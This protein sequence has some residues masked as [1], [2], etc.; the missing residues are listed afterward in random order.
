MTTPFRDIPADATRIRIRRP[1]PWGDL[2]FL[3]AEDLAAY[4]PEVDPAHEQAIECASGP[5]L[6]HTGSRMAV[7]EQDV[8]VWSDGLLVG[9]S[10]HAPHSLRMNRDWELS[11]QRPQR[12]AVV[13]PLLARILRAENLADLDPN[14]WWMTWLD[15][16][17]WTKQPGMQVERVD[18]ALAADVCA[19]RTLSIVQH[20]I[21]RADGTTAELFEAHS[22]T[23]YRDADPFRADMR[24]GQ[25][26]PL[27]T[28]SSLHSTEALA[29][30]VLE[31]WRAEQAGHPP[32]VTRG[33]AAALCDTTPQAFAQALSRAAR[34][35]RPGT[36]PHPKP[37]ATC[38]GVHWLDPRRCLLWWGS[39]PGHGPG[40]GHKTPV[41]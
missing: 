22:E 10:T 34:N 21:T 20:R 4:A 36:L 9:V 41:S 32:L 31:M 1:G 14:D 8:S 26:M 6:L 5:R 7:G 39:R 19:W 37:L 29:L 28:R 38:G 12:L 27:V 25:G 24:A 30:E 13:G 2:L 33:E 17:G 23:G 40:R 16:R 15:A 18:R 35:R 11:G 3:S